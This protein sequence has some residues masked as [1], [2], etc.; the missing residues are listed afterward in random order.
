MSLLNRKS[1]VSGM[2]KKGFTSGDIEWDGA[3]PQ[4]LTMK[5]V[6]KSAQ[7]AKG[8]SVLT[9]NI[10]NLTFPPGILVGTV[11]QVEND[12]DGGSYYL[13]KIKTATNFFNLQYAYLVENVQWQEQKT[14]E[15]KTPKN[16]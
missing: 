7:V 15:D 10:A 3:D 14:L 2:L 4:Y 13:L 12:P 5:K 16:E 8:D 11:A 6:T 1:K 9:S